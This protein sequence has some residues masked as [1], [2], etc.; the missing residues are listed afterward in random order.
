M[1]KAI[2]G[3]RTI[4]EFKDRVLS[5]NHLSQLLWAA[6]GITDPILKRR[7]V[8]SA[9]ALYPL[10]LYMVLGEKGVKGMEAGVYHY[11]PATHSI[12]AISKGDRRKEIGSASLGQTWVVQAPVIFL[13]TA[14]Y[15]RNA[16]KYGERGIRYAHMEAGHVGQNLF[17]QAEAIGLGAGIVGAFVD[18]E[19]SKAVDLPPKHEPLLLMPV[20]YRK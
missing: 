5:L 17:L 15:K 18:G 14:E 12:S 16:W 6:E 1:E 4:R 3:R 9:G 20:G 7:S 19:V 2:N 13:I 10:D 8:P 11:S